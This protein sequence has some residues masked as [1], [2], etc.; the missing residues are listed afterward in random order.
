MQEAEWLTRERVRFYAAPFLQ[1]GAWKLLYVFEGKLQAEEEPATLEELGAQLWT[2]EGV[3][4]YQ[5]KREKKTW[6]AKNYWTP[7][8]HRKTCSIRIHQEADSDPSAWEAD[9]RSHILM[10]PQ[11]HTF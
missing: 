9:T 11:V 1:S 8:G 3:W 7:G 2:L 5:E 10:I 6:R 4:E